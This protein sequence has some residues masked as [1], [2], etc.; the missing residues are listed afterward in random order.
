MKYLTDKMGNEERGVSQGQTYFRI[1]PKS[2]GDEGVILKEF[3][4][5][6]EEILDNLYFYSHRKDWKPDD[7]NFF[8]V[9]QES[10]RMKDTRL[11]EYIKMGRIV[12]NSGM[13]TNDRLMQDIM[14]ELARQEGGE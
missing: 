1:L 3:L 6:I 7:E 4:L 8:K 13:V 9:L 14:V 12:Y 10:S 2:T 5:I 11:A